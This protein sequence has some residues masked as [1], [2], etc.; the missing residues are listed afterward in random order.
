MVA[1]VATA[2]ERAYGLFLTHCQSF[3]VAGHLDGTLL[4]TDDNDQQWSKRDGLVKLWLYGTLSKNLFKSTFKTGGTSR[5]IWTRIENF[6]RDNK[7]ARAI[8]LDHDLRTKVIGD[9]TIHAYSQDLKSTA[10][11]LANVDA[12]VSERTLV[13]YM[14]N[15]LSDKFDNIINVIMHRQPF[16]TFEQARSMLILEEEKLNKGK[17]SSVV[18]D[19]ASSDK[20]L[21][22]SSSTPTQRSDHQPQQQQRFFNNRGSKCNNYRGRGRH[23][24]NQQRPMYNQW[25][26]PFWPAGYQ[27][28]NNQQPGQWIPQQQFNNQGILGPRPAINQQMLQAQPQGLVLKG[29]RFARHG[30]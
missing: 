17:K 30:E 28:W 13:T 3:D 29:D 20:V 26:V 9:Q 2:L 5:E 7:E 21:N 24:N 25:G 12:P 27:M 6:F 22:V 16:P 4:P 15:G 8:Q 14:I 10:D 1:P 18:K 11:L 19:S 23:N